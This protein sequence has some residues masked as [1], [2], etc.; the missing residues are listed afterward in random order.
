[1]KAPERPANAGKKGL[2]YVPSG[3]EF[4]FKPLTPLELPRPLSFDPFRISNSLHG[5]GPDI[6]WKHSMLKWYSINTLHKQFQLLG[7]KLFIDDK[8]RDS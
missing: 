5:G 7:Q 2:L 4:F 1:M 3:S 8:S 6:F